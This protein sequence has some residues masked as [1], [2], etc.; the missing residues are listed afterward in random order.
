MK[1]DYTALPFPYGSTKTDK[2]YKIGTEVIVDMTCG[3]YVK[4]K[5][6]QSEMQGYWLRKSVIRKIGAPTKTEFLSTTSDAV[7]VGTKFTGNT[8]TPACNICVRSSILMLKEDPVW[9]PKEGSAF[10][11]PKDGM[12]VRQVKGQI[13]NPGRASEIK[14]DMDLL[15]S[16]IELNKRFKEIKKKKEEKW[17]AYFKRLQDKADSGVIIVGTM[18][19]SS[20]TSGH[21]MMI[22]PGGLMN[23]RKENDIYE[24]KWGKSFISRNIFKVPRVLECGSGSRDNEA[25]LCRNVDYKGATKR[26][27]WFEFKI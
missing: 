11:D 14:A 24:M 22:T 9:F 26:L 10:Y 13:T 17:S 3:D 1:V 7:S 8:T 6:E 16:N 5:D 12:K 23:V 18:L 2:T 4:V 25:P 20:G 21:V 19:S 27:K 15:A